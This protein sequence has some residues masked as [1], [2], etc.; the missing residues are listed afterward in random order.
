MLSCIGD[1]KHKEWAWK[2]TKAKAKEA[3][4]RCHEC[5]EVVVF[6]EY[7]DRK[8]HFA[9]KPGSR[10]SYGNGESLEH[11]DSK[12]EI[13]QN[14]LSLLSEQDEKDF[15]IEMEY[16]DSNSSRNGKR[17]D[18]YMKRSGKKGLVIEIQKSHIELETI[19]DRIKYW[20]GLGC[21]VWWIIPA[22]I[23]HIIGSEFHLHDPRMIHLPSW[24]QHLS[25]MMRN[26]HQDKNKRFNKL[27]FY[28]VKALKYLQVWLE[29]QGSFY[30]IVDR[31]LF[32]HDIN[33]VNQIINSIISKDEG[34]FLR[35]GHIITTSNF[36]Y[37]KHK[38]KVIPRN[39]EVLS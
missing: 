27:W 11:L 17:A 38:D 2:M 18:I 10:C 8:S 23:K 37:G 28:D 33:G 19:N 1:G 29:R 7:R 26:R 3:D 31:H 39:L 9:H 32:K 13:Y 16:K 30:R 6:K 20:N 12:I 35:E 34:K 14:F 21:V 22:T 4:L 36:K 5:G 25:L 24:Q 15:V